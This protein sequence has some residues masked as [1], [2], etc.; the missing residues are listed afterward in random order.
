[1]VRRRPATA[2]ARM[3]TRQPAAALSSHAV[4]RSRR[5]AS[6]WNWPVAGGGERHTFSP[7]ASR[8]SRPGSPANIS[9]FVG[10]SAS[11]GSGTLAAP[12]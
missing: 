6:H 1:M 9:G 3:R 10:S 2:T 11:V 7:R 5:G 8:T 4:E 12:L